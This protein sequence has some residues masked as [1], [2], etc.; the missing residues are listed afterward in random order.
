MKLSDRI[1]RVAESQTVQFTRLLQQLRR[2]GR[3]VIDLAVGEPQLSTPAEVIESTK[4]AL[5]EGMTRYGT[6]SGLHELKSGLARQFE[7][8][9]ENNIIISNGSKQCLFSIFQVICNPFDEVIIP[10]ALLGEY[11]ATGQYRRRK[12]GVCGH[13]QSPADM[14]N[15]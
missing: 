10:P 3:Q 15:H 8:Y 13:P 1:N 14:R 11:S 2:Q 5:D 12:T 6:V 9:D 4:R 7:G